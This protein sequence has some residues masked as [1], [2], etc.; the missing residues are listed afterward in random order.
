MERV[1]L[2][3]KKP[4]DRDSVIQESNTVYYYQEFGSTVVCMCDYIDQDDLHPYQPRQRIR[5]DKTV[6]LQLEPYIDS[7]GQNCVIM[8]RFSFVKHHFNYFPSTPEITQA[9][10]MKVILWGQAVRAAVLKKQRQM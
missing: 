6:G 3:K 7:K 2:S 8:K 10:S 1:H 9:I 5:K 4:S